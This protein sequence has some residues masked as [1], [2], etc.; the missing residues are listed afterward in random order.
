MFGAR[1]GTRFAA[2]DPNNPL[3]RLLLDLGNQ[4]GIHGTNDSRNVGHNT[5]R[6]AICLNDCD[7]DD[8]FGILSIGS[9]VVIQR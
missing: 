8:L 9:Q 3:G 5:G 2:G 1:D 4:V 7:I 6:G